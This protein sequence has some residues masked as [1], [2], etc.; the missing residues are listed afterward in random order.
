[1]KWGTFTTLS[2]NMVHPERIGNNTKALRTLDD[3]QNKII[4]GLENER[5][6]Y[7]LS[8]NYD[9][10]EKYDLG[11]YKP[12]ALSSFIENKYKPYIQFSSNLI[13]EK[14]DEN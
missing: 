11:A 2:N 6:K 12:E 1:M 14:I 5:V 7:I 4:K 9:K 8:R 3:T 10:G 13:L